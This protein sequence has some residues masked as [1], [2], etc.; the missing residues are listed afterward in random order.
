MVSGHEAQSIQWATRLHS[1]DEEVEWETD[2][3]MRLD[4]EQERGNHR[5]GF[6]SAQVAL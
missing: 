1:C 6:L 4:V 2:N 3:V 5:D